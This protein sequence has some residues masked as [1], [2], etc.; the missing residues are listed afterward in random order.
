MQ[1]DGSLIALLADNSIKLAQ[2][3]TS[4][5]GLPGYLCLYNEEGVLLLH[6]C[7]GRRNSERLERNYDYSRGVGLELH[8]MRRSHKIC[9]ASTPSGTAI[10]LPNGSIVSVAASG[11][12][13]DAAFAL[14]CA[15]L[16]QQFS[17]E[18]CR[19]M[20]R[21]YCNVAVFD[22]LIEILKDEFPGFIPG[23]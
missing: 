9:R 8:S 21:S 15:I 23:A 19:A 17:H 18:E 7:L 1:S 13:Y 16:L 6:V 20:L 2:K 14:V 3:L 5:T 4:G 12:D 11:H 22:A 10:L